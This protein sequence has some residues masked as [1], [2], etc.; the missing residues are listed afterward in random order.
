MIRC[1]AVSM[2]GIPNKFEPV[3]GELPDCCRRSPQRQNILHEFEVLIV[4]MGC[5]DSFC[6]IDEKSSFFT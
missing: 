2:N 3:F 4:T 5:E 6:E 1:G